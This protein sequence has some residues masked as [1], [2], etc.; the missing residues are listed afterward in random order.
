[1]SAEAMHGGTV[2]EG[3]RVVVAYE[4]AKAGTVLEVHNIEGDDD[5]CLIQYDDGT[6]KPSGA[7][8]LVVLP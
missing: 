7:W 6:V 4:P 8:C 1:M 3:A 5:W 2:S